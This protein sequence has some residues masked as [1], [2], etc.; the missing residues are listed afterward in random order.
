[1]RSR[2]SSS[3]IRKDVD[4]ISVV[5]G[6]GAYEGARRKM[7]SIPRSSGNVTDDAINLL[8]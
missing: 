8:T 3:A 7:T 6:A 5:G 4:H 1:L 2:R